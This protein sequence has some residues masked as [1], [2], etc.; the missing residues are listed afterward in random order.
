MA[1]IE[2]LDSVVIYENPRP[3]VHSRHG[4]FPAVVQLPSGELLATHMIAEAFEAPNGTT[5]ISRSRDRGR[6]WHLAA[7]PL[8]DKSCVGFETTD[9]LKATVLRDGSLVAIGYRFHRHDL[10]SPIAIPETGGILP[11]DDIVAFSSDGGHTWST[12][13]IIA[14]GRPEL[15][16]I[17]GPC[18]ELRSGELLAVAAMYPLPDGSTP[19]GCLGIVLRSSDRGRTWPHQDV[20]YRH[21][22][23]AI[24]P[25]EPRVVEMPDGRLVAM[26]WAYDGAR[27]EH[28]NNQVVASHDGG[29]TWSA[30]GDT[31]HPGQ[32][33]SLT[34]FGGNLLLTI[35]AQRGA[36]PGI[37]VR[38]IDFE[39]DRWTMLAESAIYGSAFGPQTVAGQKSA[40]MFRSLRFGQPSLLVLG[41]GEVLATHWC[42][43][44]GQGKIRSH[45]L[46]VTI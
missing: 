18:I 32:A 30:P 5:W 35:H 24:T 15:L 12:P 7:R 21:P 27:G 10:E 34:P 26:V 42:V 16:E 25:Y 14:R 39:G 8:Y 1:G 36:D 44:D 9:A 23:L 37:W 11:G 13:E 3:H 6:T 31:G 33:S 46:R 40:E 20:F 43:E 45:H 22:S 41:G 17:S 2:Y 38:L 19:S 29:D 28:Y 4:Y